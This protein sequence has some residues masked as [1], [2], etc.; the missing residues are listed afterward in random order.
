[1]LH[2]DHSDPELDDLA[3]VSRPGKDWRLQRNG[4][5]GGAEQSKNTRTNWYHPI[6]WTHIDT[7][8]C[9]NSWSPSGIV[10]Q[11]QRE[12]PALFNK[13]NKGT[14]QKW[15]DSSTKQGWSETTNANVAR[16][17]GSGQAGILAKHP[18][19]LQE[20]KNK[21]QGLRKSGL[22]VNVL[23]TVAV[24]PLVSATS[25]SLAIPLGR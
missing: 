12:N 24:L 16:R 14:V 2:N 7:S 1:V 10:K 3:G 4:K 9:R 5:N 19:V 18:Q 8:A 20:I 13:L 21:L 22:A 15:I 25:D 17:H 6:L 11:L 23:V